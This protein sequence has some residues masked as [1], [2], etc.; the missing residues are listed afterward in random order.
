MKYAGEEI[1]EQNIYELYCWINYLEEALVIE[2]AR[3]ILTFD[4]SIRQD[5]YDNWR[6]VDDEVR[7]EQEDHAR[8]ELKGEGTL[9]PEKEEW[10]IGFNSNGW[11]IRYLMSRIII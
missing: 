1:T 6:D 11:F 5:M 10:D 4:S 9:P 8:R 2:R 7:D 3:A